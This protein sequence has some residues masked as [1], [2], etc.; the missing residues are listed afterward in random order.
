MIEV[1]KEKINKSLKEMQETTNKQWRE[2]NTS[3]QELAMENSN[4][5]LKWKI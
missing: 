2:M 1:L 4:R 3:V 5:I